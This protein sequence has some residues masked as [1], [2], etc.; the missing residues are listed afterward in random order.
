MEAMKT[1][2]HDRD[3]PMHLWTWAART[4]V[5]VHNRLPHSSLG[6]KTLEEIYTRNNPKVSHLNIFGCQVYV[7]I[8]K[9]RRTKL[10]PSEKKGIFVGYCEVSK[11]FRI[12]NL[13]FDHMEISRDVTFDKKKLSIDPESVILNKYMKKMYLP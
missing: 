2:I 6:F 1:M 12:Y 9:E 7:H 5:Y 13:G 8:P 11:A 3:L 4:T 10:D